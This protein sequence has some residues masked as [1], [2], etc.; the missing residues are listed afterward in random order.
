MFNQ[1]YGKNL[2]N[3]KN[4]PNQKLYS[5]IYRKDNKYPKAINDLK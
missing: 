5:R 1:I 3:G 4:S 2:N